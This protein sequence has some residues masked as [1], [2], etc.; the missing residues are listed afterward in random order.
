MAFPSKSEIDTAIKF[1]EDTARGA[2]LKD[3]KATFNASY[4]RVYAGVKNKDDA[5]KLIDAL[6]EK[7]VKGVY[8]HINYTPEHNIPISNHTV[9]M[10]IHDKPKQASET[11]DIYEDLMKNAGSLRDAEEEISGI[12]DY[13]T[14]NNQ[15]KVASIDDFFNFFRISKDTLVHKAEKDLWKVSEDEKGQVVIER[16]FDPNT[17]QPLR[18]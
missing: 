3:V 10:N 16:L 11:M 4:E 5:E 2:G 8:A 13:L 14:G 1:M 15:V 12:D 6:K 18:I 17:K 9:Y 7:S